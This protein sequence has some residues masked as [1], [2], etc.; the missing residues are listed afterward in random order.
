K[1]FIRAAHAAQCADSNFLARLYMNNL[2]PYLN[3]SVRTS[4]SSHLGIQFLHRLK[5]F[6]QVEALISGLELPSWQDDAFASSASNKK[7]NHEAKIKGE[8]STPK[9][10]KSCLYCQKPWIKGHR[11]SEFLEH[12]RANNQGGMNKQDKSNHQN[13]QQAVKTMIVSVE[14]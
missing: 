5:S 4:L 12:K 14:A 3:L 9:Q 7:R 8:T 2:Q 13:N 1:R 6:R 10:T 11:C